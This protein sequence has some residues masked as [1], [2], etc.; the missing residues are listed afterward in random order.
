MSVLCV[1]VSFLFLLKIDIFRY[2]RLSTFRKVDYCYIHPVLCSNINVAEY[3]N[4]VREERQE[5]LSS[6]RHRNSTMR[7]I[8]GGSGCGDEV[9][10][11]GSGCGDEM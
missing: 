8:V 4:Y 2:F 11:G 3:V 10:C 6:T 7:C 5:V 1:C 9:Y